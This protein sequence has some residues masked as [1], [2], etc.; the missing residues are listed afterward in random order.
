MNLAQKIKPTYEKVSGLWQTSKRI[1]IPGEVRPK[2][3]NGRSPNIICGPRAWRVKHSNSGRVGMPWWVKGSSASASGDSTV[4]NTISLDFDGVNEEGDTVGTV[5]FATTVSIAGWI[6]A[7]AGLSSFPTICAQWSPGIQVFFFAIKGSSN[8]LYCQVQE[9]TGGDKQYESSIVVADDTWHFVGMTCDWAA[10]SLKIYIDG[11]ED[12]SVTKV[13]DVTLT[14][15]NT[16]ADTF[17][18]AMYNNGVLNYTGQQDELAVW[19][20][21]VLTS[22]EFSKMYNSKWLDLTQNS[23]D[24][25]SKDNLA[26]W[27]RMGDHPNDTNIH[28]EDAS[29]NGLHSVLANMESGDFKTDVAA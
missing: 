20:N 17:Q 25:V 27:Y 13:T 4:S 12:T 23:G 22:D 2:P 28:L 14:A 6:K 16:T 3:K 18:L 21:T 29:G 7:S 9:S 5:N 24:Y 1:E 8:H 10:N 19:E 26:L 11:A 15:K